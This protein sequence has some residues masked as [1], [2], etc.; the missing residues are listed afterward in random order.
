M[1]HKTDCLVCGKELT[2]LTKEQ[3]AECLFCKERRLANALCSDGH[4][5]CDKCHGLKAND[6]IERYCTFN[7][8]VDP[9]VSAMELMRIGEVKMHGPEHHFLVPAAL[10]GAGLRGDPERRRALLAMAR[11]RAAAVPGG[12]CGLQGACGAAIGVG[13]FVSVLTGAPPLSRAEWR[14]ANRATA[15]A[16]G[17]IAAH[18]GPRCCK[19]NTYLAIRT[20]AELAC[21]ELGLK[22]SVEESVRC[23]H[24]ARN[25]EC[26][27]DECPFYDE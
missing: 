19:R 22:L 8:V 5:V 7:D 12:F 27:H 4:Y 23:E 25:A 6:L 20:T 9:L 15:R 11:E 24:A 3:E 21:A 26:L 17:V 1:D 14:L 18:G 13:I 16:L 2:Y 10:L